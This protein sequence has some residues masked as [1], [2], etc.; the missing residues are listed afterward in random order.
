MVTG[1]DHSD[2]IAKLLWEYGIDADHPRAV[3]L[4][5]ANEAVDAFRQQAAPEHGEQYGDDW[6]LRL[7]NGRKRDR[8]SRLRSQISKLKPGGVRYG[9]LD[10]ERNDIEA[11]IQKNAQAY[12]AAEEE[13]RK[14]IA[15]DQANRAELR[16]LIDA[17]EIATRDIT[18]AEMDVVANYERISAA[19]E[20]ARETGSDTEGDIG[21][22]EEWED[23]WHPRAE[24]AR[25]ETGGAPT[26]SQA[27][28][29]VRMTFTPN[30]RLREDAIAA[31]QEAQLLAHDGKQIPDALRS[32]MVEG[33]M[34]PG[35]AEGFR[36]PPTGSSPQPWLTAGKSGSDHVNPSDITVSHRSDDGS[37]V[38]IKNWESLKAGDRK[39]AMRGEEPPTPAGR[40]VKGNFKIRRG[41]LEDW[42]SDEWLAR[43][44]GA[45]EEG[46]LR[47]IGWNTAPNTHALE[48][49]LGRIGWSNAQLQRLPAYLDNLQRT[50]QID[51]RTRQRRWGIPGE[52]TLEWADNAHRAGQ[53]EKQDALARARL[54]FPMVAATFQD[55]KEQR[56]H[57]QDLGFD[58]WTTYHVQNQQ[59]K[60]SE[61]VSQVPTDDSVPEQPTATRRAYLA[62]RQREI[63]SAEAG[64]RA[65]R[66]EYLASPEGHEEA[67]DYLRSP[68]AKAELEELGVTLEELGIAPAEAQA[69]TGEPSTVGQAGDR[70]VAFYKDGTPFKLEESGEIMYFDSQE[71]AEHELKRERG[72]ASVLQQ[73][74]GINDLLLSREPASKPTPDEDAK[75]ERAYTGVSDDKLQEV[76]RNNK[77][78][79]ETMPESDPA[80]RMT[81]RIRAGAMRE[82]ER[83]GV[84]MDDV[85]AVEM[86][87]PSMEGVPSTRE[88]RMKLARRFGRDIGT[89]M[90]EVMRPTPPYPDDADAIR[91]SIEKITDTDGR[92]DLQ[93]A[94]R[95]YVDGNPKATEVV[96]RWVDAGGL[97]DGAPAS[98]DAPAPVEAAPAPLGGLFPDAT[99]ALSRSPGTRKWAVKVMVDGEY[100]IIASDMTLQ[101]ARKRHTEAQRTGEQPPVHSQEAATSAPEEAE[102]EPVDID[103]NLIPQMETMPEPESAPPPVRE[104][105]PK[106]PRKAQTPVR[107][108]EPTMES[109]FGIKTPQDDADALVER[110]RGRDKKILQDAIDDRDAGGMRPAEFKEVMDMV[111]KRNPVKEGPAKTPPGVLRKVKERLAMEEGNVLATTMLTE[112]E[113]ARVKELFTAE[114]D[115]VDAGADRQAF[116]DERN[117]IV[118]D[119]KGRGPSRHS[120]AARAVVRR[121]Q[122]KADSKRRDTG[123]VKTPDLKKSPTALPGLRVRHG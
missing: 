83:R 55:P 27:V 75:W 15:E 32:R 48:S 46:V 20:K 70:W 14:H 100:Q 111:A 87:E 56:R 118:S 82:L 11:W 50:G 91:D 105:A 86:V 35:S 26:F 88:G 79:V 22:L 16:P 78:K 47:V 101:E 63:Q 59:K 90:Q 37:M 116:T 25:R 71:D 73:M 65:G 21:Q 94:W 49:M 68:E 52:K 7:E 5:R 120:D 2:N 29:G 119:A 1:I 6:Y 113:T 92:E 93:R 123:M 60:E 66:R 40:S 33:G 44:S 102:P 74:Q 122:H 36:T 112:D 8:L 18:D 51:T 34:D 13:Y 12:E 110:L 96:R 99:Y 58:Y 54:A 17:E 3:A 80:W 28:G 81:E 98:S 38:E 53:E 84:N 95:G 10:A 30:I 4:R 108:T 19:L 103:A 45:T 42:E 72:F 106:A 121:M 31:V 85:A 24:K 64:R 104:R 109:A 76:Y 77:A 97:D 23:K 9:K 117:A 62:A 67:G 89:V 39:K 107:E 115:A 114:R 57:M 69:I 43:D 61:V 41:T